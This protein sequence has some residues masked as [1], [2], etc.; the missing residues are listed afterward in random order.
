MMNKK[1]GW[2]T[3][4]MMGRVISLFLGCVGVF[5]N[6]AL[7]QPKAPSWEVDLQVPLTNQSI[8]IHDLLSRQDNVFSYEDG[9]I[10]LRAE[11]NF[12]TSRVADNLKIPDVEEHIAVDIP[13][14][15]IPRL[16]A[17]DASFTLAELAPDVAAQRRR[18]PGL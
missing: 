6:C 7:D 13:N 4:G 17:D 8:S 11:G 2:W 18:P 12:D 14:L 9:L 10:G 5:L 1:K 3:M 16:N 15:T